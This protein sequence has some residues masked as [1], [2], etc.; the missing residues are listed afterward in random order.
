VAEPIQVGQ[1][2][3]KNR[4]IFIM[5]GV[6]V[7]LFLAL[8]VLPGLLFGGDGS[9]LGEVDEVNLPVSGGV[10]TPTTAPDDGGP[11]AETVASFSDKN[12]FRPLV[13][14]VVIGE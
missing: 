14:T 2:P 13:S 10:T 9:D 1:A 3:K 11:V 6:A 8:R 7:G 4:R 5:L 12:P